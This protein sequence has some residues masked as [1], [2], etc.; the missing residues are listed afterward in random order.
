[1]GS[2]VHDKPDTF[3]C[4]ICMD[5]LVSITSDGKIDTSNMWFAP[6][7]KTEHWSNHPCGH[8]CCRSC[9]VKWTETAINDQKLRIK[10]PAERC[11]YSLWDQ[12]VQE[13]VSRDVF[14]RHREHKNA[15]YL[16][17]LKESIQEN[18]T[19]NAWLKTNAR[20][21]PACHVIVS[22]S[23]GCNVMTCVCGTRFCYSCGFQQCKCSVK[24]RADIWNPGSD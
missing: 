17:H 20:P 2:A 23:E 22:R 1:M 11:P 15:D 24:E 4:P 8:A 18:A 10:C 16:K 14:E 12:D 13:L 9:M 6:L 19:L 7:R 3:Q 5:P 21:C